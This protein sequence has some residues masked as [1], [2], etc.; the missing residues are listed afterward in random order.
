LRDELRIALREAE[1][2]M[3]EAADSGFG[4]GERITPVVPRHETEAGMTGSLRGFWRR[5]TGSAQST[6]QTTSVPPA[7]RNTSTQSG[8]HRTPSSSIDRSEL[9]QGKSIAI[10]PFRNLSGNADLGFYEFSLADAVITE[11]ARLRSLVV[12]PSSVI[13]KYQGDARDPVEIARELKVSIVLA[14]SYLQAGERLRVNA[15]LLDVESGALLWSDRIDAASADVLTLQDTIAA[16]IVERLHLEHSTAEGEV[17][18]TPAT[19]NAAAYEEYLRGRD[20][21]GRFIYHTLARADSDQQSN[22]SNAPSRLTRISRSRIARSARLTPT[23]S[24]RDSAATKIFVSLKL[25]S[26]APSNSI[27]ICSKRVCT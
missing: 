21:H 25:R 22:T 11:L 17:I 26:N 3:N 7:T 9:P 20:S 16:R 15:Q 10:L 23:K 8:A 5:L 6:S 19:A 12:R 2:G 18:L 24:S 14:A 27:R 1:T 13:A 4:A